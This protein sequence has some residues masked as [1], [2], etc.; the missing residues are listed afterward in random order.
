MAKYALRYMVHKNTIKKTLA[1]AL[2]FLL[3]MAVIMLNLFV[4]HFRSAMMNVADFGS[5]DAAATAW[6]TFYADAFALHDIESWLLFA[7]G[8]CF[9]VLATIDF[10]KTDDPYPGFGEITRAYNECLQNYSERT[11]DSI[12]HLVELR[13]H[14]HEALE[15]ASNLLN[16][17]VSEANMVIDSQNRWKLLYA[18]HLTQLENAGRQLLSFYRSH[19]SGSRTTPAPA[20][21]NDQWEL[22]RVPLPE[23]GVDFVRALSEFKE[24]NSEIKGLYSSCVTRIGNAF[25]QSLHEYELIQQLQPEEMKK[26]RTES[27]VVDIKDALSVAA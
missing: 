27:A 18:N 9:S 4:A 22:N 16:A 1:V 5:I 23:T 25:S 19:N 2:C 21:F 15:E 14:N 6:Q 24:E 20:Y 3:P 10:W 12:S 26:W 8:C 17:K 7:T 13:D 11:D